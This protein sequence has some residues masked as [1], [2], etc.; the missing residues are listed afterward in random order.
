LLCINFALGGVAMMAMTHSFNRI[1]A[2]IQRIK[3]FR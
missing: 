3:E 2:I 1:S